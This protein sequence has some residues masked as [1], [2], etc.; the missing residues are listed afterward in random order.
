M[1]PPPRKRLLVLSGKPGTGKSTALR[2]LA[3]EHGI[4]LSE[5]NDTF[6]TVQTWRNRDEEALLVDPDHNYGDGRDGD[7]S[8][9]AP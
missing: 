8:D 6:G 7:F 1:P 9:H 5:W 3:G 4:D 2:V